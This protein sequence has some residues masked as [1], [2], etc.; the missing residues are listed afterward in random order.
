MGSITRSLANN[1]TTGGVILPAGIT[2]AS[3]SAVTSFANAANPANLVLI[4]TQTAS[5]SATISFT[6]GLNSTYDEY[7]FKF[8]DIHPATDDV[9]FTFNMSTDSGSNYNVTKTTTFFNAYHAEADNSNGLGY[10]TGRDLAQSTGF[11][12]ISYDVGNGNDES[13]SGSLQLFNPA[14]TTYVK[15][16]I[17]NTNVYTAANLSINAYVAGYGNTTSA[18][19]AIQ[20]KMSSGNIDDG[21]IKLY[22]VKKS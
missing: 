6:T 14:S 8:I 12:I 1:I 20:F 21:V 19:N 15:H 9:D 22:G 7:I 3:V 4:S 2:N 13:C 11:Q 18:V 5:A 16:F 10:D 17:T